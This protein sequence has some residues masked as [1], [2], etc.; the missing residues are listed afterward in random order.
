MVKMRNNETSSQGGS[1]GPNL[2]RRE[3]QQ[4]LALGRLH[5]TDTLTIA[6]LIARVMLANVD[7]NLYKMGLGRKLYGRA[8]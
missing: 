4:D 5:A 6:S 8:R 3:S 1:G 2:L 7:I